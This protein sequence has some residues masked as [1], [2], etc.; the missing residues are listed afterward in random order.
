MLGAA[1]TVAAREWFRDPRRKPI[2]TPLNVT[3]RRATKK[4]ME[5][6]SQ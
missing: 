4:M 3:D 1:E 5:R 6:I 2:M